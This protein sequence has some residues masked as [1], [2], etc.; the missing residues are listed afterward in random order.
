MSELRDG[1][2]EEIRVLIG[3]CEIGHVHFSNDAMSAA[4]HFGETCWL[5]LCDF[6]DPTPLSELT[7]EQWEELGFDRRDDCW[8]KAATPRAS[9]TKWDAHKCVFLGNYRTNVKLP[10]IT[11]LGQLRQLI[12]AL[13]GG[14]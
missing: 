3:Q 2:P 6:K 5:E 12:A 9:V 1:M 4:L 10:N 8:W 13:G 7:D 14:E 11:T